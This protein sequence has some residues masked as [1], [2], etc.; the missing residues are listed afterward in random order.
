MFVKGQ[1]AIDDIKVLALP[2]DAV[3]REGDRFYI[4]SVKLDESH[5]AKEWQF[6]PIEVT[7]GQTEAGW[8]EIRPLKTLDSNLVF[9]YK[10]A[11]YI[12]SELKKGEAEHSH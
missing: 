3:V 2:E 9:A 5:N 4:F 11:F 7:T 12:L 8:T 6:T 1:S 10:N